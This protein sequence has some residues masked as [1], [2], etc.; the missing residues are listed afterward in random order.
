MICKLIRFPA[1][2][3]RLKCREVLFP[4]TE[5]ALGH[6]GDLRDT[7]AAT[8]HGL[9]IAD[10]QL[11]AEG[12]RVFVARAGLGL[13]E[14][15]I[16][17]FWSSASFEEIRDHEGCLSVPELWAPVSASAAVEFEW[18]DETGAWRRAQ[19][20]G[21]AARVIQHECRHLDGGTIVDC[22]SKEKQLE[23]RLEA[24]RNRK[25]GK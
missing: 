12:L 17:P 19:V 23:V 14:V 24:I 18:Q 5:E 10:N 13:P 21:L 20:E 8:P 22:V 11:H 9:A 15:A 6:I 7:L 4:L 2:S 25:R 16:N 1:P 3:L